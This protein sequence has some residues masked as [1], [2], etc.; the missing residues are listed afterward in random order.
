MR[1]TLHEAENIV[2]S[3]SAIF[4]RTTKVILFGSRTDD[5]SRGGDIDLY[6]HTDNHT[7]LLEKRLQYLQ[8]LEK[9][10]GEQKIDIIFNKD[11]S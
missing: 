2:N 8:L 3:A 10:L 1:I 9:T 11:P 4:G 7:D 6:I 5:S